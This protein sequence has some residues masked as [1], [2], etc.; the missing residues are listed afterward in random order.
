LDED[1]PV[2]YEICA[3]ASI[4]RSVGNRVNVTFGD[5]VVL[6]NH[7]LAPRNIVLN[8]METCKTVSRK[9]G[10]TY[11]IVVESLEQYPNDIGI[12]VQSQSPRGR[13][14][15]P[16][17]NRPLGLG[18]RIARYYNSDYQEHAFGTWRINANP[19]AR[20]DRIVV[21][22]GQSIDV[23][24]ASL[25][26]N[27][28]DPEGDKVFF[29]GVLN[30]HWW[31]P[32]RGVTPNL[33]VDYEP[34]SDF[35]TVSHDG[36]DTPSTGTFVY[37]V[38]TGDQGG[39]T[40]SDSAGVT[41]VITDRNRPPVAE[42][43]SA[44]VEREGTVVIPVLAN[45]KDSDGDELSVSEVS[46]PSHGTATVIA[47]GSDAGKV[48]YVHDGGEATSDR[49]T[50]TVS[51]GQ[52]GTDTATVTV[53]IDDA[54]LPL[55]DIELSALGEDALRVIPL[56]D[57]RLSIHEGASGSF[58]IRLKSEPAGDVTVTGRIDNADI[59]I[60]PTRLTFTASDWD[61]WKSVHIEVAKDSDTE[62]DHAVFSYS[63]A[64]Y[65]NTK[66]DS[67]TFI[68]RDNYSEFSD[69]AT[70]DWGKSV[71]LTGTGGL[72]DGPLTFHSATA[73]G[74]TAEV[75]GQSVVFTHDGSSRTAS[76]SYGVRDGGG[77]E[78]KVTVA[79]TPK[80]TAP[81]SSGRGR[82]SFPYWPTTRTRTAMNCRCPRSALPATA[83]QRSS[84]RGPMPARSATFTTAA[85]R[86]PT[87]SPIRSATARAAPIQPPSPSRSTMPTSHCR[88]SSCRH[89][90]RMR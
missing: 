77:V 21:E 47:S 40:G 34:G 88:I 58:S 70:V 72:T 26:E 80:T 37:T 56:P 54:D 82:W 75:E 8:T 52:G 15:G 71:T 10:L 85:K 20:P 74:G 17:P 4:D 14:Y 43:D 29:F 90:A 44:T 12:V 30:E 3:Y 55:P 83:R 49:F 45:D 7:E 42:D 36:S 59:E 31:P 1:K 66:E 81:R 16:F 11:E 60:S 61:T 64:G 25:L 86:L 32:P 89:W 22:K 23:P 76:A 39:H 35:I 46:P 38:Y 41:V 9:P 28:S 78:V 50:Y 53:T 84:P 5:E 67:V 6:E 27:D 87:A 57:G 73:S 63:I 68:V 48:R 18:E 51:D 13:V 2:P 62:D 24:T 65:G 69:K 79:I 33:R 19:V